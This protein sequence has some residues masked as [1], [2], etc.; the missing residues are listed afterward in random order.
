MGV[1]GRRLK[2]VSS[3]FIKGLAGLSSQRLVEE[4]ENEAARAS[5][6][7]DLSVQAAADG[8]TS[9]GDSPRRGRADRMAGIQ[10]LC[11]QNVGAVWARGDS[12]SASS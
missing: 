9:A 6:R 5:C 11:I 3:F 10:E 8:V 4:E 7:E 2:S 1:T 12:S